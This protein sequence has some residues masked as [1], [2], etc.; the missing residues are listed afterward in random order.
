MLG[1]EGL[2]AAKY[3]E[4][5]FGTPYVYAVPYGYSG[6]VSFLEQVG[7]AVGKAPE[8]MV[9]MRIKMKE[10]GM[11]MLSMF[12]MMG[13]SKQGRPLLRAIMT[14]CVVWALSWSRLVSA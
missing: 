6:T 13:G 7:A 5:K 10:K 2:A 4:E 11:S 1:N 3:L 12:A 14:W 9:L 8:P